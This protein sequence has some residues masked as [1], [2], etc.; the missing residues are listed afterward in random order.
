[1]LREQER[2]HAAEKWFSPEELGADPT[3]DEPLELSE[4][5]Y[6]A[7]GADRTRDELLAEQ[8][9]L[10][11]DERWYSAAET[12]L[13]LRY[14]DPDPALNGA[15]RWAEFDIPRE[16]GNVDAQGKNTRPKSFAQGESNLSHGDFTGSGYERGHIAGQE[17]SKANIDDDLGLP[18][19]GPEFAAGVQRD[20]AR[21]LMTM[22]NVWAMKGYGSEGVNQGVF[23]DAEVRLGE[24][25]D[26]RPDA[27]LRAKIEAVFADP[28]DFAV[29][30]SGE[31]IPVPIAFELTVTEASASDQFERSVI[32]HMVVQ[33]EPGGSLVWTQKASGP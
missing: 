7:P 10:R 23:R 2:L 25:K 30:T 6:V 21:D 28:P 20:I 16:R 33:N 29:G 24:L 9:Q 11:A 32:E 26:E 22:S 15:P 13:S 27:D 3:G 17:N 19:L 12:G 8:Q 31:Q 4:K 14:G 1:M 5:Q 18:G